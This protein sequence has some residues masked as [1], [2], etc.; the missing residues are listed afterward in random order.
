M[1]RSRQSTCRRNSGSDSGCGVCEPPCDSVK[2]CD[3]GQRSKS[4]RD[5]TNLV[6]LLC[7]TCIPARQPVVDTPTPP[8]LM[9]ESPS[10]RVVQVLSCVL[11][12]F[13]VCI[14]VGWMPRLCTHPTCG[15]LL[16]DVYVLTHDTTPNL[17][18]WNGLGN[19]RVILTSFLPH[20]RRAAAWIGLMAKRCYLPF[21]CLLRMQ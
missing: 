1:A 2:R 14:A 20:S 13:Y 12:T 15:F 11:S 7:R 17:I 18:V 19:E 5:H 3:P 9:Q 16:F 21:P 8:R 6:Q 4:H 10:Q